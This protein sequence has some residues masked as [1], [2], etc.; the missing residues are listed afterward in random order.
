MIKLKNPKPLGWVL[1]NLPVVL[2]RGGNLNTHRD[3]EDE[4]THRKGHLRPHRS[5]EG[6]QLKASGETKVTDTSI[7]DF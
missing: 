3:I 2:M 6:S 4:S 7:L 1:S 5:E